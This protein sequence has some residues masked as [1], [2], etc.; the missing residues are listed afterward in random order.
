MRESSRQRRPLN[1]SHLHDGSLV[2][3][4]RD[5]RNIIESRNFADGTDR[6]KYINGEDLTTD[7]LALTGFREP[8]I[9]PYNDGGLGLKVPGDTFTISDVAEMV[10]P[11]RKVEVIDVPTQSNLRTKWNISQWAE[12]FESPDRKSDPRIYNIISLEFSHCELRQHVTAPSIVREIDWVENIWPNK[13][14]SPG[15]DGR[16]CWPQVQYYCL[17]SVAGAYTDFHIDFG[18]SS[19]WYNVVRGE[20][21]FLLA[22]PTSK[23]LRLYEQWTLSPTQSVEF[24]ADQMECHKLTLKKGQTLFIPSGWIHAVFTPVDTLVFGGNFLHGYS[25]EMQFKIMDLEDR[26]KVHPR[27]RFPFFNVLTWYAA[28]KYREWL[29]DNDKVFSSWEEDSIAYLIQK[30]R[31]K[32]RDSDLAECRIHRPDEVLADLQ[33]LLQYRQSSRQLQQVSAA[34]EARKKEESLLPPIPALKLHLSKLDV[35]APLMPETLPTPKARNKITLPVKPASHA[36]EADIKAPFSDEEDSSEFEYNVDADLS[37]EEEAHTMPSAVSKA[38]DPDFIP[39]DAPAKPK[40][41]TKPKTVGQQPSGQSKTQ[42]SS[43]SAIQKPK[44][45]KSLSNRQILMR[46]LGIRS[47][48][49]R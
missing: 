18:G 29:L 38:D 36:S 35:M 26:T 9:V 15:T 47:H 7:Y 12:Y 30:L 42:P 48:Q 21:N 41:K 8:F 14:K 45:K 20:K 2:T 6:F 11:E 44:P 31:M 27:F 40:P 39:D 1:Y 25:V 10:G 13:F 17:M 37:E 46:K 49:F 34:A 4:S 33:T 23:N 32:V 43:K 16:V 19:V 5:F 24:L 3:A 22:P 28:V